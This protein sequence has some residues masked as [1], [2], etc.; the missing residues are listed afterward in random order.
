MNRAALRA[1]ATT[2]PLPRL[3]RSSASARI[4]CSRKNSVFG[5]QFRDDRRGNLR[6]IAEY[7]SLR[8][9][10][11]IHKQWKAIDELLNITAFQTFLCNYFCT[12]LTL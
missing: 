4:N 3:F 1:G 2:S 8:D 9:F 10:R 5:V 7:P 12:Q 11:Q 6:S